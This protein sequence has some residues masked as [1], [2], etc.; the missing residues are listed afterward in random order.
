MTWFIASDN[1]IPLEQMAGYALFGG[2]LVLL[3]IVSLY[4]E[5]MGGLGVSGWL[6]YAFGSFAL[7]FAL[8]MLIS[9]ILLPFAGY[10][11]FELMDSHWFGFAFLGLALLL[12][13]IARR[14]L[15]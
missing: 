9:L 3:A 8:W 12:L 2:V 11:G 4:K 13:P 14:Y 10:A 7:A 5:R 6:K 1:G 15:R